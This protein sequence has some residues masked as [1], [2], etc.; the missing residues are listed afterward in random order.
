MPESRKATLTSQQ[1][2][3]WF[4]RALMVAGSAILAALLLD[5]RWWIATWPAIGVL[6]AATVGLRAFQFALGKYA[7]VS[8]V[9]VVALAGSLLAGPEAMLFA[10]ALGTVLADWGWF[11][12]RPG[13]A[14]IN[15]C[16]EVVALA[17][18]Y[19]VY[20]AAM[21][22]SGST[23]PLT[24]EG[25]PALTGFA[26]AYFVSS[27]ALFY[28]SLLA[29]GK[30]RP[31][32]Q[33]LILRYEI[34]AYAVTLVGAAATVF[35]LVALPSISWP[36]IA[37]PLA[38]G[39]FVLKRIIEEAIQAEEMN[40]IHAM[41]TVIASSV[42]FEETLRRIE[43]LAHRILDWSEF[44]IY[45]TRNGRLEL[46]HHGLVSRE[47]DSDALAQADDLR[48]AAVA[49]GEPLVVRDVERDTR[50]LHLPPGVRSLVIQP[51][52]FGNERIG[53]LELAH[54]RR[55]QYGR[56]ELALIATCASRIATAIHITDLRR[57]LMETVRRVGEQVTQLGRAADVLRSAARS[58]VE[59]TA[60]IGGGLE[61]QQREVA[62][63]LEATA[64]LT[65][66]TERVVSDSAEA[67]RASL[68][69][70]EVAE[71]HRSTIR[72]AIERLVSLKAVVVEG[73]DK[74]TELAATSRRLERFL[75]SIREIADLTNLLALN[76]AIE[77]ARAGP[78][79]KGFGVVA[80]EVRRLAE[81]SASAASE[82]A[83]LVSEMQDRL[84]EVVEQMRRGR[85]AV[86][87]VEKM[88]AEGLEALESIVRGSLELK[89]RGGR[90]AR[91]AEGQNTA[92]AQLRN[93]MGAIAEISQ[94]NEQDTGEVIKY[95]RD[96]AT[97]L[98][99][100]GRTSRELESVATML[101]D[102]TQRFAAEQAHAAGF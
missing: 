8:Q 2:V 61:Q 29:R 30:L 83:D 68:G 4:A 87:G 19:G 62:G 56:K 28:F 5:Y 93:R 63:G 64:E 95:V 91:T 31:E 16:R 13:S 52:V 75:A 47:D 34:V 59:A 42:G 92:Y 60:A 78:H 18:A 80:E 51:L 3:D 11:R 7:Y 20:A 38:F 76:A 32:E 102:L 74:V 73:S 22:L 54:R 10:L 21:A 81:Q 17:S 86:G 6:A 65:S 58:M 53:T 69:V 43:E 50:T 24:Y 14:W 71:R 82:S 36:F 49:T 46:L 48:S 23:S 1:L 84:A 67:V 94:R 99:D 41:E 15:A 35:T 72:D 37:A 88:S 44:R 55:H 39:G 85:A 100:L 97:G 98:E 79:G 70:G 96:V 89:E 12:K 9:G 66:A 45:V 57:P 27:R 77:A 40:K 26:I 101:A 33:L 25:V 90:I